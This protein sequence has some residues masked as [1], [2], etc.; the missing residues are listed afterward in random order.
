V[1]LAYS[2]GVFTGRDEVIANDKRIENEVSMIK[3][4]R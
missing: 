1:G 4:Q 2:G 3:P